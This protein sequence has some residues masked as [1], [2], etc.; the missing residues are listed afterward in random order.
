MTRVEA[1]SERREE[2]EAAERFGTRAH[3]N[4][5]HKNRYAA[6]RRAGAG[7][8]KPPVLLAARVVHVVLPLDRRSHHTEAGEHGPGRSD[9]HCSQTTSTGPRRVATVT[10]TGS[11]GLRTSVLDIPAMF[12]L[13]VDEVTEVLA[14]VGRID[15]EAS[16]NK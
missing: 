11:Q 14:P 3:E 16:T 13:A 5:R 4:D 7:F 8:R 6:G 9:H 2:R 10:V 12:P 1:E 15:R